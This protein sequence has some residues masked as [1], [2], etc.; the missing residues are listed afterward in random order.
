LKKVLSAERIAR[1]LGAATCQVL[2]G[3]I[4]H[5]DSVGGAIAFQKTRDTRDNY[6]VYL[7]E[8]PINVIKEQ[9]QDDDY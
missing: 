7:I 8:K 9:L 3:G 2:K 5:L 6:F 4:I 1:A